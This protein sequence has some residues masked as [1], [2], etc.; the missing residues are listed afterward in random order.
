[1][2]GGV[3]AVQVDGVWYDDQFLEVTNGRSSLQPAYNVTNASVSWSDSSETV[4]ITL[5]GKNIFDKAYRAYTLNLGILGTTSYY[6]PPATYGATV[7]LR[8]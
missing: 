8:W 7:R 2:A 4:E 3:A 1:V 5:W 6:A